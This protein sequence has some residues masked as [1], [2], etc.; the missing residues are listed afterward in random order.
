MWQHCSHVPAGSVW[1]GL[2]KG[3]VAS[4]HLSVWEKTVP[5]I[6]LWCQTLQFLS[7]YHWYLSSRYLSIGAQKEWVWVSLCVGSLM[8]TAWDSRSFFYQLNPHW[9]C[10]QKLWDL[11][12]CHWNPG[13]GGLVWGWYSSLPRYTSWFFIH[14]TCTW[15]QPIPHL[16]SSYQY[17]WMWFL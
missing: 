15:D 10:S 12:S 1:G 9:C 17:G 11:F 8:A 5:L 16:R 4:A 13:L 3:T 14:H 7:V 2:S 6:L